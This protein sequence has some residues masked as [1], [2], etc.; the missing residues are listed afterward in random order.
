MSKSVGVLLIHGL[1]G[2]PSEMRPV[3]KYFVSR[4]FEVEVPLL[5]GHGGSADE[6]IATTWQVWLDSARQ[7]LRKLLERVD[8]VVVCGLSMGATIAGLLAAEHPHAVVGTVLLSPTLRYDGYNFSNHWYQRPFSLKFVHDMLHCVCHCFPILLRKLYWTE[9]APYGLKDKRLQRVITQAIEEAK[10]GTCNNFGLFRTYFASLYQMN[11]LTDQFRKLASSITCPVLILHS[12]ED[13]TATISN[14][15]EVYKLVGAS[16]RR[17][18]GLTGC[19]H[20]LTL[21]LQR[22]YVCAQIGEFVSSVAHSNIAQPG[23]SRKAEPTTIEVEMRGTDIALFTIKSPNRTE[24]SFP[25]LLDKTSL[26][27]VDE[28]E[29]WHKAT[30]F[31]T[32]DLNVGKLANLLLRNLRRSISVSMRVP[33]AGAQAIPGVALGTPSSGLRALAE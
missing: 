19:D 13:T 25:L 18:V 32:G 20:V 15:T 33:P 11:L 28:D 5:A 2:M 14:A 31:S 12:M 23:G 26:T 30:D 6:L 24:I 10:Q 7:S 8:Q 21:D 27:V 3:E 1:T 9:T 22:N 16:K 17:L 29:L 4:G